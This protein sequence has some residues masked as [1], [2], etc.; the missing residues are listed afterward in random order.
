MYKLRCVVRVVKYAESLIKDS[1]S[2]YTHTPYFSLFSRLV[3]PYFP[4][5]HPGIMLHRKCCEFF[6]ESDCRMYSTPPPSILGS[7]IQE[8]WAKQQKNTN[9]HELPGLTRL[10]R[11]KGAALHP[12]GKTGSPYGS[13]RI[14][15]TRR[16]TVA[17]LA[18]ELGGRHLS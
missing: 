11:R 10:K 7:D 1:M 3:S 5:D 12:R 17:Q 18:S 16:A 15:L 13:G 9:Q 4:T 14:F 2:Y 8:W 6:R